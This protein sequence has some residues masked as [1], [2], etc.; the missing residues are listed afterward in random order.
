MHCANSSLAIIL[1]ENVS[2]VVFACFI[3]Y[4]ASRSDIGGVFTLINH[5]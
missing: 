3:T 1:V 5:I 2:L 4:V